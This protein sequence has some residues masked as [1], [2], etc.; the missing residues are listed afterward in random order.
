MSLLEDA[1]KVAERVTGWK[2]PSSSA[3]QELVRERKP[4]LARFK[5]DGLIPN[6][7]AWPLVLYKSA[8]GLPSDFDPAAVFE[9]LFAS[10]GWGDSWRNGIY[11]YVHYHSRIH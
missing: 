2:K 10:N 3:L 7:P 11:D 4:R 1:K 6:H 5:D 9:E 8:A